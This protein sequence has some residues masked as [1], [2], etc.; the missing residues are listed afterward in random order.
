MDGV[1]RPGRR[2][3]RR[4]PRPV[5]RLQAAEARAP[6]P[7]R[8]AAAHPDPLHQHDQPRAGAVLPGRRGDRAADPPAHPLER[9]G[10]GAPR[11]QPV[12]RHRRAPRHVRLGGQPVR[13]R[14]QPLLP[15]QG[16]RPA[17][18]PDLLPGPR[19]SRDLRPRV[20]RGAAQRG[21]ARPLP[22]RVGPRPGRAELVPAPAA[23]AGL[24]GVPDGLDGPRPDQLDLPGPLQPLPPEPRHPRHER[25]ARLG[26]RRRRRDR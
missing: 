15:G 25:I 5:P 7:D 19:G 20:P 9:C 11:E 3:V 6:A 4:D 8:A 23:H 24:L 22:A 10:D 26:V 14:L 1:A 17:R 18:R 13:G 12:L 16:Q 2:A 21:P